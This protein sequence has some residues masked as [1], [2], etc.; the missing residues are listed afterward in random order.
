MH[1]FSLAVRCGDDATGRVIL[2]MRAFGAGG[3][4]EGQES[5]GLM[6]H[7]QMRRVFC[8][9]VVCLTGFAQAP[10]DKPRD[11]ATAYFNFAMG[12]M[13]AELA[14]T[15]QNRGDYLTKAID[16]Y[17]QAIKADPAAA[18]LS[19]ELSELYIQSGR[20]RDAV[21][22][23]EEAIKQNPDDLTSRRILGRIYTRMIGDSQRGQLNEEMLK[24]AV[25][26]Y[27]KITEKA[28]TEVDAWLTLGRLHRVGH[29]SVESEKAYR[30][31]LDLDASSEEAMTGLAILYSDL[32]DT[33][34]S[35]EMLQKVIEKNP[36]ARNLLALATA[37]EQM[38]D[39]S[40]AATVLKRILDLQ[41]NNVEVK[42]ALAQDLLFSDQFDE[43][44]KI[45][46]EMAG[47]D[48]KDA[49]AQ[50]R[51]S[52]IYRQ[53]RKFEAAREAGRKAREIEPNNIEIRYNEVSLLEAEGKFPEAV[54]LLKD[55]LNSTNKRS[56]SASEK[57]SRAML[58]DRLGW[59]YRTSEQYP[60]AVES[61]R[62][63]VELDPDSAARASAQII[64]TWRAA[65]ELDKAEQEA[66][67]AAKKY[68]ADRTIKVVR[69]SLLADLGRT[70]ESVGV[71]KSL[72][73][74]KSDRE[75]WLSLAQVYEKAK[76]FGEQAKA[77]DEAEKLSLSKDEKELIHFTRGAMLEKTKKYD[78]AEVEFRK[79]I[80]I[81]PSNGS[82]LNYLGYM[83]AD[84][85]VRLQEAHEMIKKAID[86]DPNNGAYLDSLGWVLYRLGKFEEAATWLRRAL[87]RASRDP[88]V[89][90]HLG[91]V[92]LKLGKL[93]DAISQWQS[94]LKE[95]E[96]SP[97]S[98]VDQ[99]EI[100]KVQKKLESAKVRLA[101]EGSSGPNNNKN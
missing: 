9:L 49:Q 97:P 78:A 69:A 8:G 13:Y 12:H 5:R 16:H 40:M 45:Y 10:A 7:L 73:D 67:A 65:K 94:S 2:I 24:R 20:L 27:A 48:P 25:E 99:A 75:T 83:L 98:E 62:S 90:D 26:Q 44:L 79:V 89:H 28:P 6:F 31:A 43:S 77:I 54:A 100:A 53:Q 39:Y 46:Q 19:E 22:E 33:Q 1:V 51:I 38:R 34:R 68:P 96:T 15:Y 29:N 17:K 71:L 76:N 93:K 85:N 70:A 50:L 56:Y 32:G 30:K 4:T 72:L 86:S 60:K 63:I 3:S 82:A 23:A 87:E 61:F 88:T 95:W 47:D 64:E 41:P 37:H 42:R 55:I 66:E 21:T 11:K 57:A 58:L 36:S 14:G 18:F 52:Q 92:Y 81:N 35:M 80:E 59:L 84:R 91:D 74:G 101:K